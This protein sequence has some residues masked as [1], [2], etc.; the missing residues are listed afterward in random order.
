MSLLNAP[1]GMLIDLLLQDKQK[2]CVPLHLGKNQVDWPSLLGSEH[3]V[4]LWSEL[5][6]FFNLLVQPV[7]SMLRGVIKV[8]IKSLKSQQ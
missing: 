3:C 6:F 1:L 4:R 8:L 2:L 5:T 7:I